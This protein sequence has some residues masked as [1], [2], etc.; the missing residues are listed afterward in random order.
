MALVGMAEQVSST[1]EDL[2]AGGRG[3]RAPVIVAVAVL[4]A[5]VVGLGVVRVATGPSSGEALY[6]EEQLDRA[7]EILRQSVS[8]LEHVPSVDR[9]CY[10]EIAFSWTRSPSGPSLK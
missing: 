7:E 4:A 5:V 2:G 10:L 8:D 1:R 3:S 9:H 6:D